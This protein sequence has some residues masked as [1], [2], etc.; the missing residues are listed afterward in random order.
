MIDL[1]EGIPRLAPL[2]RDDTET[3]LARD[4]TETPLAGH[5]TVTPLARDDRD[6]PLARDDTETPLARDNTAVPLARDDTETSLARD[7]THASFPA[8]MF[9]MVSTSSVR[10]TVICPGRAASHSRRSPTSFAFSRP[11]DMS[12]IVTLP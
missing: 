12:L 11:T 5:D 7:D 1:A 4:D 8:S 10:A 6:T 9:L 2:A 3:P